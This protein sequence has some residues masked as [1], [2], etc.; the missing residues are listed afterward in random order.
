M[1]LRKTQQQQHNNDTDNDKCNKLTRIVC[2]HKHCT[3]Q[4][5]LKMH[6]SQG[7]LDKFIITM[8]VF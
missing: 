1:V 5:D 7:K 4:H 3:K 2:N 6:N 8:S